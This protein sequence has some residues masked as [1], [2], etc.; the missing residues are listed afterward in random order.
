MK[1]I[2]RFLCC[3]LAIAT[4]GSVTAGLTACGGNSSD[5]HIVMTYIYGGTIPK[6]LKKVEKAV[7]DYAEE[8]VGVTVEFYPLSIFEQ[9][10]YT[11]II[12]VDPIDLMYIGFADPIEYYSMDMIQEITMDDLNEYA[13]K[14]M[15]IYKDYDLM[16]RDSKGDII[17]ISPVEDAVANGGSYVIRTS[18]LKAIGLDTKYPDQTKI[19]F[20]DLKEIFA[21]LKTQFPTNYPIGTTMDEAGY[22][23]AFDSVGCDDM[24][25]SGIIELNDINSTK[26]INYYESDGYKAYI[27]LMRECYSKEWISRDAETAVTSKNDDFKS[28]KARGVFVGCLPGLKDSFATDVKEECTQLQIVDPYYVPLRVNGS[29]WSICG[30]SKKK[31]A[32]LKFMNLFWSDKKLMN[33][34]QWGIEGDHFTVADDVNN[35]IQYANGYTNET[36][37]YYNGAGIYGDKRYIYMYESTVMTREEQIASVQNNRNMAAQASLRPSKAGNFI[38]D[39][40]KFTSAIA[41]IK[42]AINQYAKGLALGS[43]SQ[44]DYEDMIKRMKSAGVDRVIADKQAQLDAYL[45]AQN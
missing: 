31:E 2:K 19:T 40:S 43:G 37:P 21:K 18:D 36:T 45:A 25:S 20:D 16:I 28:G 14:I 29:T 33:M 13:P 3:L 11:T 30:T 12:G 8:K 35:I 22:T 32:T 24:K 15:E 26:V 34:V 44:K 39:S 42:S 9:S 7:S 23:F 5:N 27:E 6:D 1:G 4:L 17:G 10:K 38:Y 41:N